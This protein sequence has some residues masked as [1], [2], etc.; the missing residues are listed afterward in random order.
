M[1]LY[2]HDEPSRFRFVLRGQLLGASVEELE[3][4]WRT[5]QSVLKDRELVVDVSALSLA[6]SAGLGLLLRMQQSGA[7]LVASDAPRAKRAGS[8]LMRLGITLPQILRSARQFSRRVR[9][10]MWSG[11]PARHGGILAAAAD[12]HARPAA[13]M[14]PLRAGDPLQEHGHLSVAAMLLCGAGIDAKIR[15]AADIPAAPVSGIS[16][17]RP[18]E[19]PPRSC[20]T[21]RSDSEPDS[22]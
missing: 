12:L 22:T 7:R 14:P 9:G 13:G 19:S 20:D 3:H 6:D 16:S 10:V 1:D 17:P 5:A 2:Q 8:A 18:K 21:L 4:A 11:P 15:P